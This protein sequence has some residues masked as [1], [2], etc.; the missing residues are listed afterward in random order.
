MLSVVTASAVAPL[1]FIEYQF[2][3]NAKF[4]KDFFFF[5]EKNLKLNNSC[6]LNFYENWFWTQIR[7][8]LPLPASLVQTGFGAGQNRFFESDDDGD[9]LD[10]EVGGGAAVESLQPNFIKTFFFLLKPQGHVI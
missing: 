5:F 2:L 7:I 8:G 9:V 1:T 3:K 6:F 10:D 4:T